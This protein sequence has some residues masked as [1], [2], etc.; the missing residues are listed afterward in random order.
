[1]SAARIRSKHSDTTRILQD[2]Y[3]QVHV[4]GSNKERMLHDGKF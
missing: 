1:M 3:L 4:M 2:G